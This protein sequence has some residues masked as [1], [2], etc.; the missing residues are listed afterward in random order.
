MLDLEQSVLR[1]IVEL[2]V[3]GCGMIS[4]IRLAGLC[5]LTTILLLPGCGR[6]ESPDVLLRKGRER[7]L[8]GDVEE[9]IRV[10]QLVPQG[11]Q[12]WPEARLQLGRLSASRQR[13]SEAIRFLSDVPHDGSKTALA[14]AT[15]LAEIHMKA[16]RLSKAAEAYTVVLTNSPQNNHVRSLL[17]TLMIISGQREKGTEL[18]MEL[19]DQDAIDLKDTVLL[20]QPERQPPETQH[21]FSCPVN[22]DSDPWTLYA[23]AVV[24]LEAGRRDE[25]MEKLRSSVR[26]S[27]EF[28]SALALIGES[29]L[30]SSP[31]DFLQW[32][33][34]LPES[35]NSSPDILYVVGMWYQKNSD[36]P[37]A[38]RCF[39]ECV[40]LAPLHRRA[41]FQLGQ[42]LASSD[43]LVSQQ[44]LNHAKRME[45][46]ART[47]EKVLNASGKD[48]AG[49][50]FMI[51]S[52]AE[53]GR[54]REA[55]NWLRLDNNRHGALTLSEPTQE[56]LRSFDPDSPE[57]IL[58]GSEPASLIDLSKQRLPDF[59]SISG[60]SERPSQEIQSHITFRNDAESSGLRF[61]YFSGHEGGAHSIRVF[62][63]TGGGTGIIDF[64]VDGSPDIVFTQGEMW[65]LRSR[66]PMPSAHHDCLF[67]QRQGRFEDVSE[68]AGL[69]DD[70]YGQGVCAA[71]YNNDGFPDLYIANIGRNQLLLNNGDGTFTDCSRDAGVSETAW[72]SSCLV[73]DLN[74]DGAPDL[75]DVNY[76]AGDDVLHVECGDNRCSVNNFAGAVDSVMLAN[77]DGTFRKLQDACPTTTPKG[78]G[79]AAITSRDGSPPALFVANDQVPNFFLQLEQNRYEDQALQR[80]LAVNYLGRPTACMGIAH[81]DVNDDGL[82]DLFVTNFEGEANCLYLQTQPGFF[83]DSIQGSGLMEAG[84]PM[85]GWGTQFIDADNDSDLDLAVANGHVGDFKDGGTYRMPLQFFQNVGQAQ[86]RQQLANDPAFEQRSLWRS[87]AATDWN[88]DGR[89]DFVV[90]AVDSPAALITNT[91]TNSSNWIKLSLSGTLSPR[92][93]SGSI[94]EF[95]TLNGSYWRFLSAGDG[96]QCTNERLIHFGFDTTND[97][98]KIRVHWPSGKTTDLAPPEANY[99][100]VL[101]EGETV[102]HPVP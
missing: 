26:Q 33:Q 59:R 9:A 16:C 15:F 82:P 19:L 28:L 68:Q 101:R 49:F 43:P 27:P 58:A 47:M 52:L 61:S 41:I 11:S 2:H 18:L 36:S 6:P 88:S 94:V 57:R 30:D 25:A 72:T 8:A 89:L 66:S 17:A 87:L 14:A 69:Q 60:P 20:T 40:R 50:T 77:G 80:G 51:E 96:F 24:D 34:S 100:Y 45:D 22:S 73:L 71:D 91:T 38:A 29:S 56:K 21:L 63:S 78:L 97:V 75:L 44:L 12:E 23:K 79:I 76:L 102:L 86:F 48:K 81:G 46:F 3:Q 92:D 85:V 31:K 7:A 4:V 55:R 98:Q 83:T 53:M 62:E 1:F 93:A 32:L 54:V 70:G 84:I 90:S 74:A 39:W 67:H 95:E 37:N 42:S 13:E 65:P 35:A 64:D 10:L 99:K 5:L